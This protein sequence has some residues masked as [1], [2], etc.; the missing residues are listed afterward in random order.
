MNDTFG[1]IAALVLLPVFGAYEIRK[2]DS[3]DAHTH[4]L[5][6]PGYAAFVLWLGL[7]VSLVREGVGVALMIVGAVLLVVGFVARFFADEKVR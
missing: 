5:R 1:A 7:L 3:A 2:F 4:L 6:L